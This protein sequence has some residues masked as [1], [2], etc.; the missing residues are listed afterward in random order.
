MNL[1][2]IFT[3]GVI[4]QAQKPVRVFGTGTGKVTI[5]LGGKTAQTVST[6]EK[7][8][9]ELPAFDYGGPY[10]LEADLDGT[11]QIVEDVWF[12]DVY[13]AAGQSNMQMKLDETN[14]PKELYCTNSDL[15]LYS[16]D[17]VFE[18]EDYF[19]SRDGWVL[20]DRET[21]AHWTA[22]GYLMAKLLND[23]TGRKIGIITCYQ[24]AAIVQSWLPKGAL[25]G[26]PCEEAAQEHSIDKRVK[27]Y[28]AWNQDGNLYNAQFLILTPYSVKG[29][30]WYQG[31]GNTRAPDYAYYEGMLEMLIN[32]WRKDLQDEKL[33][34]LVIQLA[35]HFHPEVIQAQWKMV[36]TAQARV[37]E[38]MEN[39][40]LIKCADVCENDGIHPPT[41][42]PVAE[43]MAQVALTL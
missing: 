23:K 12:G 26:T 5:T 3:T 31:E 29:V 6:G 36:Q 22:L 21:V 24:G 27:E 14:A 38:K 28:L 30:L 13:I 35:D 17:R 15:R 7:W 40:H 32:Q 43:R 34:F 2:P 19:H 41:K 42:L 20:A 10:T 39:V 25:L 18:D 1:N 4:L 9:L 33:P 8:V 11:R 16:T 37:A